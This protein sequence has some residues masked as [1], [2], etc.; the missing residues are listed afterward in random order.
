MLARVV[1]IHRKRSRTLG[2]ERC[3]NSEGDRSMSSVDVGPRKSRVGRQMDQSAAKAFTLVELLVVI[4]VIGLLLALLLPAVQAARE[5]ARRMSCANNLKQI[6]IALHVYEGAHRQWPAGWTAHDPKTGKGHWYGEPG[7]AWSAAILPYMEQNQ[8]YEAMVHR[9]LPIADEANAK[10]R[11]A[12]IAT[13]RCPSDQGPATFVLPGGGPY[14]GSGA[15]EPTELAASNYLGVFGTGCLDEACEDGDCVGNGM[16]F[17]NRGV[18]EKEVTDGLSHTLIVG[19]RVTDVVPATWLGVV[20]GG[21]HA[22]TRVVAEAEDP[23]GREED[24][25]CRFHAFSASHVNGTHFLGGDGSVHMLNQLI[26]PEVYRALCT[27]NGGEP[28]AERFFSRSGG[29][30]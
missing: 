18:R 21:L 7:W 25:E 22:P 28:A 15:Y 4:A 23:P 5:T 1:M 17:L 10:A 27:R 29:V 11:V 13:F 2:R 26:D 12:P 14:L 9:D 20:T 30:P 8:L 3:R 24:E 16:F 6:G 19:E